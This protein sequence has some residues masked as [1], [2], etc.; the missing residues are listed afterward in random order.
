VAAGSATVTVTTSDGNKTATCAVTVTSGSSNVPVTGVSLN[1]TTM[2]L[3]VGITETLTATITP[4]NATN[5]AVT[6][7]SSNTSVATVSV[8]GLVTPVVAGSATITVTTSDGNKTATCAVTV[9]SVVSG[10]ESA[11]ILV[12]GNMDGIPGKGQLS[13]SEVSKILAM[14]NNGKITFTINVTVNNSDAQPGYGIG[15]ICWNWFDDGLFFYVPSNAQNGP[16]VFIQDVNISSLKTVL[17]GYDNI[18]INLWSG[19]SITK[20]ELFRPRS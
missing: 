17:E 11:G 8:Y 2:N 18:I 10:W 19:A 15:N 9:T 12:L 16:I 5:K 6:W 14:P 13:S 3:T 4:S 1:K 20:A 7:R